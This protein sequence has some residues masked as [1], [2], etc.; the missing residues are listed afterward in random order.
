LAVLAAMRRAADVTNTGVNA[1]LPKA[2]SDSVPIRANHS[3]AILL[4]LFRGLSSNRNSFLCSKMLSERQ[5]G[6]GPFL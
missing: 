2:P 6:I 5:I 3:A 4:E 1:E